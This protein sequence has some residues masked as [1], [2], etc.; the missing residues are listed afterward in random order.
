VS[1]PRSILWRRLDQPGHEAAFL[2]RQQDG[3]EL[4]GSSVFAHA[5]APVRLDYL[6][7]C[8]SRW[9]TCSVRIRGW[10]GVTPIALDLAVDEARHWQQDAVECPA[11]AGCIDV[12]LGFSPAT[13]LLPIRRFELAV[14]TA[15]DVR[16]AW[17]GFPNLTLEPLD[18]R[19]ERTGLTTYHYESAGGQFRTE[20]E[21]NAAGFVTR[22]PGLWRAVTAGG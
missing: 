19:Y 7:V 21:V 9:Q 4:A 14:G 3:W 20:L 22:Y 15:A 1:A 13:N 12:D 8:D 5:G 6:I 18:Q 10:V 2:A 11:V 16:A 17:L